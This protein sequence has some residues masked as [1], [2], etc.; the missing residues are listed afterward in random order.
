MTALGT[1]ESI[2]VDSCANAGYNL[3]ARFGATFQNRK[4]ELLKELLPPL[5][6]CSLH[7]SLILCSLYLPKCIEGY[8]R[9][10][11][12]CRQV[13]FDFAK[14]CEKELQLVSVGGMTTAL[15]DLLPVYDGTPD[16]CIMPPGFDPKIQSKSKTYYLLDVIM[17]RLIEIV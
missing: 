3:T 6:S 15:C 12:P 16:K 10:M 7:S 8:G 2:K 13:C 9:P 11:L 1:C 17:F 14:R 4:G 5:K